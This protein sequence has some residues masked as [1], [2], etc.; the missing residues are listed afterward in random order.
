MISLV[1]KWIQQLVAM[2]AFPLSSVNIA[3]NG[4]CKFT[5]KVLDY[6]HSLHMSPDSWP[7]VNTW[8]MESRLQNGSSS[9]VLSSARGLLALRYFSRLCTCSG[10]DH[11]C[12][13]GCGETAIGPQCPL[14]ALW[15]QQLHPYPFRERRLLIRALSPSGFAH[16]LSREIT[17]LLQNAWVGCCFSVLWN[18]WHF[19]AWLLV[20]Q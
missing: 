16:S 10:E 6:T 5:Q 14:W 17:A 12:G 7:C 8:F 2:L 11:E 13:C 1:H 20:M 4:A 15:H 18:R 9:A 3:K 19:T